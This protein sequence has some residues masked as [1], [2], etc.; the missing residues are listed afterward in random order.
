MVGPAGSSWLAFQVGR[1][2]FVAS[3][4]SFFNWVLRVLEKK[5][6]SEI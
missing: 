6:G 5:N 3:P 4:Y 1:E 2:R